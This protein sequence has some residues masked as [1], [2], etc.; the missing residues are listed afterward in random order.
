MEINRNLFSNIQGKDIVITGGAGFI[1]SHI[2][3]LLLNLECNITVIDNML[4]G[5]KIQKKHNRLKIVNYDVRNSSKMKE[6]IKGDIL[7]HLASIVGVENAFKN[8]IKLLD[9]DI[10]G[11]NTVLE[12][13]NENDVNLVIFA[14]SSEIYGDI[15]EKAREE[16]GFHCKSTYAFAKLI[17]EEYCKAYHQE[18]GLNYICLRYFNVFGPRQDTRFVVPTFILNALNNKSNVIHGNGMQTRD[19]TFIKDAIKMTLLLSNDEKTYNDSYNI[20]TGKETSML[21]L[22]III[23]EILNR[24]TN[25]KLIQ[26]PKNRPEK[27]EVFRRVADITKFKSK[28][29]YNLQYDLKSGLTETIEYYRDLI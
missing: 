21:E 19:F 23:N 5:N 11:T 25:P 12:A 6:L 15:Q 18:Y 22:N 4:Y 13:A 9:I 1:G 28:T 17:G 8:P 10:N 20:G 16:D 26:Y 24:Q 2:I 29:K 7:F 3:D 27:I 14:S